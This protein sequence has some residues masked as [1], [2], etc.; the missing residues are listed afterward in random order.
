MRSAFAG[1]FF[2]IGEWGHR[3]LHGGCMCRS[4][5]PRSFYAVLDETVLFLRVFRMQKVPHSRKENN[6][7]Q[8]QY[9]LCL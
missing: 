9:F 8:H 3:R 7:F 6:V 2:F 1:F 4:L 5:V